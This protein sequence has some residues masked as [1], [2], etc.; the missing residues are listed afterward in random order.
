MKAAITEIRLEPSLSIH[1]LVWRSHMVAAPAVR[2]VV[3][4]E[5]GNDMLVF[6]HAKYQYIC[7][8][9]KSITPC[10]IDQNTNQN[11]SVDKVENMGKERR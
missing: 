1:R 7:K 10:K 6:T 5:T 9:C 2:V 8:T 11:R 3:E 4:T